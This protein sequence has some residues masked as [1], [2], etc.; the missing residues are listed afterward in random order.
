M[1]LD[2]VLLSQYGFVLETLGQKIQVFIWKHNI[3]VWFYSYKFTKMFVITYIY[4][5]LVIATIKIALIADH[6][7][8][9]SKKMHSSKV[10]KS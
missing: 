6:I 4:E 2:F 3:N 9:I 10:K 7:N 5:R 8:M 1:V